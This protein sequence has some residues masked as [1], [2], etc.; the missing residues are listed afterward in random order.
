MM[1]T[2][3]LKIR[4]A[5]VP[6]SAKP[7]KPFN[8]VLDR[9]YNLALGARHCGKQFVMQ[10]AFTNTKTKFN[11]EQVLYSASVASDRSD[12]EKE[13]QNMKVS[14]RMCTGLH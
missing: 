3:I 2:Q 1:K 6:M 8:N 12:N 14:K 5:F 4:Q 11:T 10:P 9:G 7:Y 13:V